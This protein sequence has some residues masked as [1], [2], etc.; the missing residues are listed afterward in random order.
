[1][2]CCA[3]AWLS[4]LSTSTTGKKNRGS[5]AKKAKNVGG[6]GVKKIG[7]VLEHLLKAA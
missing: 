1:M 5:H 4:L 2:L 7:V 3:T 6:G